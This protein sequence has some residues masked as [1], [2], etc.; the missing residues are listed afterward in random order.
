MPTVAAQ[1]YTLRD[2]VKTPADIAATFRRLRKMGYSA[3][4][5]SALGPIDPPELAR[6]LEGEGLECCATHLSLDALR[7][8]QTKILENHALWKCRYVAIGG[9]A[10]G[11]LYPESH[12]TSFAAEFSA[13]A[14]DY[15]T[16]GLRLGYHNH[17]HE[18]VP[19]LS[20]KLPMQLLLQYTSRSVWFE[21][22]TYWVQ[23]GGGDPADWISRCFGRIPVVHMKDM[24]VSFS[25][26][27]RVTA[28]MAEVGEGNLNWPSILQACRLSGVRYYV[29]EQDICQRDPF[30]S[31]EISLRKAQ[32]MLGQ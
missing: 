13:L 8:Q 27:G 23:H 26:E 31:L 30:D 4:Q 9:Y 25:P 29:I 11:Q 12:W 19:T 1:L 14:D 6:I 5:V 2:Y 16:K 17:S 7:T 32:A 3:V 21:L 10:F 15:L 28:T 20:G 24:T 18:F 22:D